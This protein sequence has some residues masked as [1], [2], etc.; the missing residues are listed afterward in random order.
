MFNIDNLESYIQDALNSWHGS[1]TDPLN[2][3]MKFF[4]ENGE[5]VDYLAKCM[6]KPNFKIDEEHIIAEAGDGWYYWRLL[7]KIHGLTPQY[8]KDNLDEVMAASVNSPLALMAVS[9]SAIYASV[10][11]TDVDDVSN[12]SENINM[13]LI[14]WI[15]AFKQWVEDTG[16][17]FDDI[18]DYNV[19]KLSGPTNHGWNPEVAKG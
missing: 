10:C 15:E 6:F 2:P 12:N 7:A 4:G 3:A 17:N 16:F 18:H 19:K 13:F 9:S 1:L 5:L 8:Y 11:A 14:M